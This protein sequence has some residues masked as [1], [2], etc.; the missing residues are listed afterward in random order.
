MM[1]NT[2]GRNRTTILSTMRTQDAVR[3][4]TGYMSSHVV[5]NILIYKHKIGLSTE[6]RQAFNSNNKYV[7]NNY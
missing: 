2:C 6:F 3:Y 4:D 5:S 7:F 1:G